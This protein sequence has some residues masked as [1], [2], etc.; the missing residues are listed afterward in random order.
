MKSFKNAVGTPIFAVLAVCLAMSACSTQEPEPQGVS[1]SSQQLENYTIAYDVAKDEGLSDKGTLNVI[2][3]MAAES[4]GLNL[5]N[6]GSHPGLKY[7]QDPKAISKS[8]EHPQSDGVPSE[9][10]YHHNGD[11]GSMGV[12]QQQFP[13]WGDVDDLMDVE[14]SVRTFINQMSRFDYEDMPSGK[15]IQMVQRSYDPTGQNYENKKQVAEEIIN[16][17]EMEKASE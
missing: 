13:W 1:L 9:Y 11:Y 5:A 17:I 3:A 10:G 15:A 4:N 16:I 6:D 8:I 14:V 2:M 7:D 12:L